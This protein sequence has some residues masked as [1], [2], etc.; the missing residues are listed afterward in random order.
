MESGISEV[1]IADDRRPSPDS[2]ALHPGYATVMQIT[3]SVG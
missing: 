2:A 1:G 3:V